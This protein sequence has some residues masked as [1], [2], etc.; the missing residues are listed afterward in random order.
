GLACQAC[1]AFGLFTAARDFNQLGFYFGAG[2]CIGTSIPFR[3]QFFLCC[4][5][6]LLLRCHAFLLKSCLLLEGRQSLLLGVGTATFCRSEIN[7]LARLGDGN[8]RSSTLLGGCLGG[9]LQQ[10]FFCSGLRFTG[11]TGGTIGLLTLLQHTC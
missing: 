3:Q 4:G 8:F 6:K 11:F 7:C 1:R 2:F 10:L 5:Q 9:M